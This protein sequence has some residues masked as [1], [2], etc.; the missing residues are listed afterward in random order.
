MVA[1][2]YLFSVDSGVKQGCVISPTPLSL[3]NAHLGQEVDN[4]RRGIDIDGTMLTPLIHADDMAHISANENAFQ[5]NI[6][7]CVWVVQKVASLN[8]M[9][10]DKT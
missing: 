2:L 6:I 10:E 9:S 3:L 1:F 4:V 7:K 8:K 5:L